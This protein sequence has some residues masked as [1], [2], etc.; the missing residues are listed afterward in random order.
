MDQGTYM[1]SYPA[2]DPADCWES[3][4]KTMELIGEEGARIESLMMELF[5][6]IE[7]KLIWWSKKYSY[8]PKK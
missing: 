7:V 8:T 5:D 4:N 6:K 2:K 1:I 3:Q